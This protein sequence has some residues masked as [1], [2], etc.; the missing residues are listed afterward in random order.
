MQILQFFWFFHQKR[1][2]WR[3]VLNFYGN[4]YL[5]LLF[6]FCRK[7]ARKLFRILDLNNILIFSINFNEPQL[8][9]KFN[10]FSDIFNWRS[11]FNMILKV[12]IIDICDINRTFILFIAKW[13]SNN[14]FVAICWFQSITMILL[15]FH[16]LIVFFYD[17]LSKIYC[18]LLV[19]EK[20]FLI[21]SFYLFLYS[22]SLLDKFFLNGQIEDFHLFPIWLQ[23]FVNVNFLICNILRNI[24]LLYL[25]II[26]FIHHFDS[27]WFY[28]ICQGFQM[29]FCL[30]SK[31]LMLLYSW[32]FLSFMI[33]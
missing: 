11:V 2:Y 20:S 21:Q 24:W 17:L 18:I 31:I 10:L 13:F 1:I 15:I 19:L 22:F 14:I 28:F 3:V 16:V 4:I 23:N 7:I 12:K 25:A 32:C 5:L 27:C 6:Y 30:K 9:I 33:V 26:H 29:F 8:I